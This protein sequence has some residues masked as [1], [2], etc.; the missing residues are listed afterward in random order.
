MTNS[1]TTSVLSLAVLTAMYVCL[2]RLIST[3]AMSRGIDVTDIDCVVSYDVPRVFTTYVHRVGRTARAGRPGTAFTLLEKR[4]VIF[5][6]SSCCVLNSVVS[7][8][9]C[10]MISWPK[11]LNYRLIE[12]LRGICIG[13]DCFIAFWLIL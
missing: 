8:T 4:E 6:L 5:L 7:L 12:D 13:N 3:D 9:Y 10:D 2:G 1:V 11:L